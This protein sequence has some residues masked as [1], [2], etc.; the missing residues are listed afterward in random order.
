MVIISA[1]LTA[2]ISFSRITSSLFRAPTIEMHAVAGLL[3][4]CRR[5]ISHR[6]TH[7]AA[8]HHH[9]AVI[10]DVGGLTQRADDVEDRVAGFER[11]EQMRGLPGRLHDR[12]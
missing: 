8:H 11:V 3:Q 9:R 12:C 1:S 5:G 2:R 7:A 10:P 6:R 4:R